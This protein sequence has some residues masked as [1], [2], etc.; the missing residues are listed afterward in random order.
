M[1]EIGRLVKWDETR[2]FGF[3]QRDA[4][5]PHVFVHISKIAGRR[6]PVVGDR[7]SFEIARD[8]QNRLSAANVRYGD[9][10]IPI[11]NAAR[12]HRETNNHPWLAALFATGA[13]LAIGSAALLGYLPV[14]IPFAFLV[15]S[16]AVFLTY[17]FDKSAA[18][19]RRQRTPENVLHLMNLLGGWPGGLVA[20]QLFRHK[21]RKLEFRAVFYSCILLNCAVLGWIVYAR[22]FYAGP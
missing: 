14:F 4:G 2:G 6:R 5:G 1:G 19:N 9:A 10:P 21:S 20:S 3:I 13:L 16:L 11:R 8:L 15:A 18:M 12:R 7:F 22:P 17:A